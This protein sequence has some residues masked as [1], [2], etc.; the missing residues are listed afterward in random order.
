MPK[1]G[2]FVVMLLCCLCSKKAWCDHRFRIRTGDNK[3]INIDPDPYGD[4]KTLDRYTPLKRIGIDAGWVQVVSDL[5]LKSWVQESKVWHP[6]K[7][8]AVKF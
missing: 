7:V 1:T 6:V 3:V 5:G 4:F 2:L 8:Q